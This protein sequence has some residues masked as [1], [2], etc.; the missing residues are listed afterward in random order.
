MNAQKRYRTDDGTKAPDT[1]D[2]Y[3]ATPPPPDQPPTT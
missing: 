2:T 1:I 3:D